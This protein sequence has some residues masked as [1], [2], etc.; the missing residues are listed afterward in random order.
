MALVDQI[1]TGLYIG[2]VTGVF[3]GF[4]AF[5]LAFT[6]RYVAGVKLSDRMGLLIGL[7]IAGIHG[8]LTRLLREPELLNSPT[9]VTAML[10]VMMLT[11][12][13][14]NKGLDLAE[15]LPSGIGIGPR[16][17]WRR[18]V[19][20]SVVERVGR[21]GQVRVRVVGEVDDVEGYPPPPEALRREIRDEEWT[22]PADLP[23]DELER[24]LADTLRTDYDL[25][26]AIVAIDTR[27]RASVAVA[28]P[29]SNLSRRV[30]T[31]R[32]A[33]AV[34]VTVPAGLAAGDEVTLTLGE[35]RVTGTV[36]S[37]ATETD[38][39]RDEQDA[40]ARSASEGGS[41]EAAE[42]AEPALPPTA[43]TQR[44]GAGR[45]AVAVETGDLRTLI[46]RD[47]DGVVVRPR[48][49]RREYEL[50]AL[51]R[52]G[53]NRF[54]RLTV[55]P[56][57][58]FDGARL[59]DHDLRTSYGADVL[60]LRRAGGWEFAPDGDTMIGA[61]DELFVTGPRTGLEELAAVVR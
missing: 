60:A 46:E 29:A 28:P 3:T 56:G 18:T 23:L 36:L 4:L 9:I 52:R 21:F 31:G 51:L 2:A 49:R 45:I 26:D 17:L 27:G 12:Y 33:A 30:P 57:S 24:R 42:G 25:E 43:E 11:L 41:D 8:G 19:S 59:G 1:V 38:G 13:A 54:R 20:A 50:V 39:T 47:P 5:L 14:H 22:F 40:D 6:F 55:R 35:Q 15:A 10:A 16:R 53:N 34:D 32:Q 58:A 37:A 7:S 61:E 48:G 44:G